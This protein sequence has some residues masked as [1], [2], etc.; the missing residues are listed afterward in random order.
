[1]FSVRISILLLT[2]ALVFCC[3]R[4]AEACDC[5]SVPSR[6]PIKVDP[7]WK[8]MLG[9]GQVVALRLV[10][11][12]GRPTSVLAVDV[13]VSEAFQNA[14][15]GRVTIYSHVFGASCYGYDFRIGQ[16]YLIATIP[17]ES[18]DREREVLPNLLAAGSQVVPLCG[19]TAEL[20]TRAAQQRLD[21]LR[22]AFG[23]K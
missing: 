9:V 18:L 10:E 13:I 17:S 7:A 8:G 12:D 5:V 15:P 14:T 11:I 19:G 22:A 21:R 2:A 1:M 3:G 23:R 20:R 6:A 4:N 16:E